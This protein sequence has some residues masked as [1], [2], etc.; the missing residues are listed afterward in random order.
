MIISKRH[1]FIFIKTKKTAGTS[2]EIA[3]SKICGPDDIITP[4]SPTDE[5]TRQQLGYRGPQNHQ[6]NGKESFYNHIGAD[7]IEQYVDAEMWNTYYK[8]CFERNPFDKVVSWFYWEHQQTNPKPSIT[9]FIESGHASLVGGPGGYDLYTKNNQ[10]VVDHVCRFENLQRELDNIEKHLNLPK[11][12]PLPRAK[13]QFRIDKRPYQEI[14]SDKDK[15]N[16]SQIFKREID[17]FN[18]SF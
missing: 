1:K 18:Y 9:E 8:F 16:I 17:M 11:I 3:L 13:S 15:D 14:L 5:A 12:P 4:I 10:L 6:I 2:L 7:Q